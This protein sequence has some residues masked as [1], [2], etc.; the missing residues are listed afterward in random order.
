MNK[1]MIVGC[2]A[3]VGLLGCA[4]LNL[5]SYELYKAGTYREYTSCKKSRLECFWTAEYQSV[6]EVK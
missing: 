2:L 4:A 3:V 5:P 6:A 1:L